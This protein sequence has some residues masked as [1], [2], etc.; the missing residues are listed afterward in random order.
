MKK[1]WKVFI[2]VVAVLGLIGYCSKQGE[3]ESTKEET[4]QTEET[5]TENVE[6]K[7]KS[8]W[9][10]TESVDEMTEVTNYFATCQ[11]TNEVEFEFPYAGGSHLS[12]VV[13]NMG[14]KNEILFSISNGQFNSGIDGQKI[15]LKVDGGEPFK[16]NCNGANDGSM[17]VLFVSNA[18]NL[19]EKI[20]AAKTLKVQVEF[21]QEGDKTFD[22]DVAGLQW[23]H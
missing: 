16:V 20:K 12:L 22:F 7:H 10:Y 23:E 4:A 8:T 6:Q 21:F 13:R 17:D 2:G 3:S 18:S 5:V 11:S 9:S 1:K 14:K 19:L 15:T